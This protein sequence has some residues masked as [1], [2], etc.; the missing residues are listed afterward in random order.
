M[1]TSP[2]I[3]RARATPVVSGLLELLAPNCHRIQVAGSYRRQTPVIHDIELVCIPRTVEWFNPE[4]SLFDVAENVNGVWAAFNTL[5]YQGRAVPIGRG[6]PDLLWHTKGGMDLGEPTSR[7]F[8][9]LLVVPS[10]TVDV[11]MTTPERWG[12]IMTIRT[13]PADF[14][15]NLVTAAKKLGMR[16]S[17]G[18]LWRGDE[19][20]E[21]PE[22]RNVFTE[23]R[24]PWIEPQERK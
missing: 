7:M 19:I 11:F 21:T 3:A 12:C 22:E 9:V 8:K 15:R 16:F 1:S 5:K 24:T 4:P 18:R 13:G 20:L 17:D 23:M 14:S 2:P 6:T 10:I